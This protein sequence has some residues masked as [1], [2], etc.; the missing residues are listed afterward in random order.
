LVVRYEELTS[1]PDLVLARVADRIHLP[2]RGPVLP[3]YK[4]GY[5]V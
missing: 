5:G 1:V 4:V 3:K 2:Y